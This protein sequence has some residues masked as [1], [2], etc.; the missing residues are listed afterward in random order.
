MRR[1]ACRKGER[2]I[3]FLD[4]RVVIFFVFLGFGLFEL[5]GSAAYNLVVD[6]DFDAIGA[7]PKCARVQVVYVLTATNSE[8]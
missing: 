7:D 8:V 2:L 5:E 3:D 1:K 6:L 4:C